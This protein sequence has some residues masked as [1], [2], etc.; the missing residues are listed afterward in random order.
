MYGSEAYVSK[1]RYV[2]N[3][4]KRH[5]VPLSLLHLEVTGILHPEDI[6]IFL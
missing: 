5:S 2:S 4:I 3:R 1:T 6:W